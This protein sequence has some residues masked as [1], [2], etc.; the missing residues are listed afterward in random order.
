MTDLK[1]QVPAADDGFTILI[2]SYARGDAHADSDVDLLRIGHHRPVNLA[3][4]VPDQAHRSY[5]D[6][7]LAAFHDMHAKGA[8]FLYHVFNEGILL[9]GASERWRRLKASFSVGRS[10]AEG[11]RQY[12]S[13]LEHLDRYPAADRAVM[14]Y[15]ST[16]FRALKNVGIFRLAEQGVFR[17]DKKAALT[18]GCGLP[19]GLANGLE[20]ANV[21]YE[22]KDSVSAEELTGFVELLREWKRIQAP[23]VRRLSSGGNGAGAS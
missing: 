5:I 15:L 22:R 7:D 19:P 10:Q 12:L 2:G 6:V 11:I 17:F 3:G 1:G 9:E 20:R 14:P 21:C 16:V 13:L 4:R 18:L 23:V 8:L